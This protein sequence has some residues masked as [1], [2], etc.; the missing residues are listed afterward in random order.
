MKLVSREEIERLA[1]TLGVIGRRRVG[2]DYVMV[3]AYNSIRG[4]DTE[5][6]DVENVLREITNNISDIA[7]TGVDKLN[8][9]ILG[10][11]LLIDL[12][13]I[14]PEYSEEINNVIGKF[15]KLRLFVLLLKLNIYRFFIK[16]R[17]IFS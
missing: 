3:I 2:Y 6:F 16:I 15:P 13:K 1:T 4:L 14:H 12:K 9:N 17:K 10:Y 11:Y 7:T 5:Y 8:L